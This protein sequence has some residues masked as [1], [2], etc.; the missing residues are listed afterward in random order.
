M[1]LVIAALLF[2]LGQ[3]LIWF[4]TNGQF[5][6]KWMKDH[7]FLVAMSFGGIIS[8]IFIF[9]VRYAAEGFNGQIWPGRMIAS[10]T[11]I[12]IMA[13]CTYVFLGEG[14]NTKTAVS[15]CLSITLILIQIF[16]K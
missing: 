9:A 12:S 11:G 6:S 5:M 13:V 15:L 4:Q 2:I 16:W 14:I 10:G 8:Y 3:T 7:P 1:K